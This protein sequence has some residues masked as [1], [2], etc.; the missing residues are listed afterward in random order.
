M[1]RSIIN[2]R[3]IGGLKIAD[4]RCIKKE[5]LYRSGNL[6]QV[7]AASPAFSTYRIATVCD[8]RTLVEK[9]YQHTKYDFDNVVNVPL[10]D[11]SRQLFTKKTLKLITRKA[12]EADFERLMIDTYKNMVL[13]C[14][15]EIKTIFTLLADATQLPLLIHCSAGKDRTGF[16]SALIQ[17]LLGASYDDVLEH[18]L[19]SN[20]EL[21]SSIR[22]PARLLKVI[23]FNRLSSE[24][25][26]PI[27]MVRQSYL[28][29]ALTI[30]TT[31]FGSVE[32]YLIQDCG[33]TATTIQEIKQNL[34]Q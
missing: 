28:D 5:T 7:K 12:T 1:K 15:P 22:G 25:L 32:Q 11:K 30:I 26:A 6:A 17:L 29:A 21:T 9:R 2:F 3:D 23:S 13:Y 20:D 19:A 33:L 16:I 24:T 27:R 8:L 10:V 4:G 31:N 18:Y 14:Q 34:L